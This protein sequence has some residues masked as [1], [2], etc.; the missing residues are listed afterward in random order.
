MTKVTVRTDEVGAFFARAGN[1]AS[2]AD[3]NQ[4]FDGRIT[5]SFEDPRRM[6][7]VL[8]ESRRKLMLEIMHEPKTISQLSVVLNRNRSVI[9]KD[10]GLL[11]E[12]GL[13]VSRRQANPGHGIQKLVQSVARKIEMVA[14]LG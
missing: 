14:T 3:G 1:A 7:M 13:L 5:L 10:V 9:T 4:A 12:M 2:R 6:F 8:S 11:E